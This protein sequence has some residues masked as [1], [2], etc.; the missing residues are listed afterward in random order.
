MFP[1]ELIK[2]LFILTFT[3]QILCYLQPKQ[4]KLYEFLYVLLLIWSI[5][6]YF[7]HL[8][9]LIQFLQTTLFPL[10]E[11]FIPITLSI[12]HLFMLI[13]FPLAPILTVF[14]SLFSLQLIKSVVYPLFVVTLV[15]VFLNR[16]DSGASLTRF[17]ELLR[18]TLVFLLVVFFSSFSFFLTVSGGI[19]YFALEQVKPSLAAIIQNSIPVVGSLVTEGISTVKGIASLSAIAGGAIAAVSVLSA[20]FVPFS[21]LLIDAFCFRLAG[22]IISALGSERA[23][24][25]LDDVGKLIFIALAWFL[26]FVSVIF[27]CTMYLFFFIQLLGRG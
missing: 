9:T 12:A 4:Q 1:L 15:I 22:A 11:A 17:Y 6:L 20:A 21:K 13:V 10:W 19:G 26:F 14:Y 7:E 16:V 18:A 27:F 8:Y 2:Q 24:A 23:G 3:Y 25:I 5:I